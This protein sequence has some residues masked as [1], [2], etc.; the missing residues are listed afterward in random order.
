M[1][2]KGRIFG[3]YSGMHGIYGIHVQVPCYSWTVIRMGKIVPIVMGPLALSPGS[4]AVFVFCWYRW[5]GWSHFVEWSAWLLHSLVC[6]LESQLFY[7]FFQGV[8]LTVTVNDE[9]LFNET[10]SGKLTEQ[11]NDS[12]E[13]KCQSVYQAHCWSCAHSLSPTKRGQI[14]SDLQT[15]SF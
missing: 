1:S 4:F 14:H 13:D 15:A 7:P 6:S 12:I 11:I 8:R 5:W 9:V 10:L 3:V 2:N